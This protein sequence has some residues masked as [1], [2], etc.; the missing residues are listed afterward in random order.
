M[1]NEHVFSAGGWCTDFNLNFGCLRIALMS[2]YQKPRA[3]R[4]KV[5]KT[6]IYADKDGDGKVSF[7]EFSQVVSTSDVEDTMTLPAI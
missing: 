3:I 6:I 5:D 1:F 4:L 2:S 7:E